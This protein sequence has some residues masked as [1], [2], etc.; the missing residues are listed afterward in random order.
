[1]KRTLFGFIAGALSTT[2]LFLVFNQER[3]ASVAGDDAKTDPV[4]ISVPEIVRESA[5]T[6]TTAPASDSSSIDSADGMIDPRAEETLYGRSRDDLIRIGERSFEFWS[7]N[8]DRFEIFANQNHDTS[9]A[10]AAL[11]NGV[12]NEVW[13]VAGNTYL[14]SFSETECRL[15]ACRVRLSY[16]SAEELLAATRS[17]FDSAMLASLEP[18]GFASVDK[19]PEGDNRALDPASEAPGVTLDIYFWREARNEQ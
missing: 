4:S 12:T 8:K 17:N 10:V 5:P 6:P 9:V 1:M 15:S 13:R 3:S 18:Y 11:E 7:E 2:G 14:P 19:I 16:G